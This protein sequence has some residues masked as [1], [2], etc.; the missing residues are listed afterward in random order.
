MNRGATLR[1]MRRMMRRMILLCAILGGAFGLTP[2]LFG[3]DIRLG[4]TGL[5]FTVHPD[6]LQMPLHIA[7]P[8]EFISR[9]QVLSYSDT[10][11]YRKTGYWEDGAPNLKDGF[12][13]AAGNAIPLFRL[14]PAGRE[15]LGLGFQGKWMIPFA[16]DG[17]WIAMA[18]EFA[19]DLGITASFHPSLAFSVSRKHICSHLLD[20]SLFT[21]GMRFLGTASQDTDPEHGPM[22]IRDSVVFSVHFA[23]EK[24]I[25]PGQDILST[26]LYADYGYSLPGGDPFSDARYT[27]P[28]Y[29]TSRYFQYG[30]QIT[31]RVAFGNLD[32]GSLYAACNFSHYE[33]AGY[34][35]NTAYS[36]GYIL[37]GSIGKTRV[38]IDVSYYDGRAVLEEY[39]GQRERYA[40]IGLKLLQ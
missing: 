19:L 35:L 5:A 17:D 16:T 29:R 12:F 2:P 9:V 25:F 39:Y 6:T 34:T 20:R 33:S 30:A 10:T 28:S 1:S 22:A 23:P 3:D 38:A 18:M 37:P 27:R 11:I 24:L 40:S 4:A 36:A 13:F 7:S 8:T 14:H 21:D 32:A 31:V 26:S 15:S